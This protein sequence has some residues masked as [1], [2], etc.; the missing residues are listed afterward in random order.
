MPFT[1]TRMYP[2][3]FAIPDSSIAALTRRGGYNWLSHYMITNTY[4][5]ATRNIINH[6][7]ETSLD[8]P[9]IPLT[10]GDPAQ[11]NRVSYLYCFSQHLVPKPPDWH[12]EISVSGFWFL[13][14][15]ETSDEIYEPPESLLDFLGSG[16][17]PPIYIGF[18]SIVLQHPQKFTDTIFNA[19]AL[20][21]CR[22]I[23]AKGWGAIDGKEIDDKAKS[24]IYL[25]DHP[26]PHSWLFPRVSLVC[27]HG[28]AGTTAAGLK[29]G[30][31][32]IVVEFFGDQFFWGKRVTESGVGLC[33]SAKSLTAKK[34]ARAINLVASDPL[35]RSRAA[36]LGERIRN[37]KGVFK[38]IADF[39]RLASQSYVPPQ[40]V[41]GNTNC[42]LCFVSF[43][44]VRRHHC[45]HCGEMF[46]A[47]CTVK[48]MP[49]HKY[50]ISTLVRV[51]NECYYLLCEEN[52]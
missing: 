42:A 1:K 21:G 50:G 24:F 49:I 5:Q 4:W 28:G 33:L 45:R 40:G 26:I 34:L 10:Q 19:L 48:E 46:C 47:S 12:D 38:A 51:C 43:T 7:R 20:S 32:T 3:P 23:L 29:A 25:S 16:D 17:E 30:K 39:E 14:D 9:P 22:A 13:D 15:V 11:E 27:H 37:E 8:L 36:Q 2:N 52:E 18:G 44:L 35:M 31:P 41:R 6:W